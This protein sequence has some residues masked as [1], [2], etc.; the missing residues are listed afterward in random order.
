VNLAERILDRLFEYQEI[1]DG[2]EG[3][4]GLGSVYLKRYFILRNNDADRSGGIRNAPAHSWTW[5][6]DGNG[7]QVYLHCIKRS[8]ADR[9]LHDHPWSFVSLMLWRGY[10]EETP[11]GFARKWPGM[12][13]V[14]GTTWRHRV[15]IPGK[16]AWS[17][18]FTSGKKRTWGFWRDGA[19]IPWRQFIAKKCADRKGS[20]S[21]AT[22]AA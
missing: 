16:Q 19:F 11:G 9:E 17:L 20:P 8:D 14:R 12:V 7:C 21:A 10:V 18:V 6:R 15:H 2:C 5:R 13:L 4:S 1:R 22:E 3:D